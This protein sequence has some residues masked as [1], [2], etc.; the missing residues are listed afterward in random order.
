MATHDLG[1]GRAQRHLI[2]AA[3]QIQSARQVV[4]RAGSFELIQKPQTLLGEGQRQRPIAR[5]RRNVA[6]AGFP[7]IRFPSHS[8]TQ[9]FG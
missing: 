4:S 6:D 3:P 1:Q 2:E 5:G 7:R 8:R 9:A